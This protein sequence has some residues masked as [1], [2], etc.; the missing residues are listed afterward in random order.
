[1]QRD[2]ELGR[3]GLYS[4]HEMVRL[5]E[6]GGFERA[7][8]AARSLVQMLPQ[9]NWLTRNKWISSSR[10]MVHFGDSGVWDLL[11]HRCDRAYRVPDLM[12]LAHAAG[13]HISAFANPDIYQLPTPLG[14]AMGG[15]GDE[16][17]V[18]TLGPLQE[19]VDGLGPLALASL[20]ELMRGNIAKHVVYVSAKA[21]KNERT[22]VERIIE[23]GDTAKVQRD[24]NGNS[25]SEDF[26]SMDQAASFVP[27]HVGSF[28]G[29]KW[30][31]GPGHTS[32]LRQAHRVLIAQVQAFTRQQV[33]KHGK[34][35][36]EERRKLLETRPLI[37][38]KDPVEQLHSDVPLVAVDLLNGMNCVATLS[39][40]HA[41]HVHASGGS[42]SWTLE[43]FIGQVGDFYAAVD[44]DVRFETSFTEGG[45]VF[46]LVDQ[47]FTGLIDGSARKTYGTGSTWT[48]V[49]IQ[50]VWQ[51]PP[52]SERVPPII[53]D[54][55]K[56]AFI[57]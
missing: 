55:G 6:T 26:L 54:E 31:L 50:E 56:A 53:F 13:M 16:T 27:C 17:E 36:L 10:D 24:Q 47:P 22:L 2:G 34:L 30:V 4:F 46:L 15:E 11:L 3:T 9:T 40:I 43:Q 35:S 49:V 41:Q 42:P 51:N 44:S 48:D 33:A 12:K 14:I 45:T 20:A 29:Q 57:L 28:H 5:L 32:G 23:I 52:P 38:F 39:N 7:P 21:K 37:S 19:A 1:M 8:T 18:V 25:A